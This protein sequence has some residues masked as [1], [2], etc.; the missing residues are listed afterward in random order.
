MNVSRYM[1]QKL[2]TAQLDDGVRS[3]FFRMRQE[4]IRHMPVVDSDGHLAGWITDR[5]LRRP[6]WADP[7]VDLAH[8]YQLDDELQVSDLMTSTPLVVHTY[9]SLN[10]AVSLLREHRFGAVPV[11]NK[12]GDL[13]GVLSAVD[14]LEALGDLLDAEHSQEKADKRAAAR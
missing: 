3:V 10:K 5:D 14:L 12:R 9:D 4:R 1:T 6:D 2:H 8:M 7:D 13:V 11:L